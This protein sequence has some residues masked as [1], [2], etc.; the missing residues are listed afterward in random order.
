MESCLQGA[1]NPSASSIALGS[2]GV[3]GATLLAMGLF[4]KNQMPVEGKTVL[5]TGATEGMG[6]SAARQLAEKGANVIVVARNV[7]RLEEA[8]SELKAAETAASRAITE[9]STLPPKLRRLVEPVERKI[10]HLKSMSLLRLLWADSD[11][12]VA[13]GRRNMDVNY[14]G[15]AEMAHAILRAWYDPSRGAGPGPRSEPKHLVFTTSVLAFFALAGYAPYTPSKNALRGLA[16]TLSQEALLYP[17]HPVRIHVVAPGTILSP[18]FDREQRTKPDITLQLE[19]DDPR[20][21][22]DQ[23]ATAA[24]RGLERGNYLVTVGFLGEVLRLANLGSSL[25]NN[26]FVDII[27]AWLVTTIWFFVLWSINGD[28]RAYA[29]KHGHPSTYPKKE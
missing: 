21:T 25:R 23:V 20:Q 16:D 15:S 9:C 29:K 17:D 13:A 24:I 8:V 26:W 3:L 22:P 28:I 10:P 5:L 14:W 19:K 7:A 12:A 4:R 18:G 6:R 2:A 11:G 27:G 1:L